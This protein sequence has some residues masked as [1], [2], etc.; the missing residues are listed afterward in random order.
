[1][2]QLKEG[3]VMSHNTPNSKSATP[4]NIKNLWA[5]TPESFRHAQVLCGAEFDID[6]SAS[7][8]N[9]KCLAYLSE[10]DNAISQPW[11]DVE[12]KSAWCNPPF[13]LKREFLAKAYKERV[14]GLICMM[15]PYEPTT[16]WWREYV[17]GKAS[18]VYVPDGRYNFLHPETGK[19][20]KGVSFASCFV[21][22]T[23][24]MLE[25][26]YVH[27]NRSEL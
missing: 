21:V 19:E 20:I 3:K 27:F 5:T 4:D 13:D 8:N 1:M 16:K 12:I 17:H 14:N 25:T 22:F 6:V 11:F 18:I 15:I 2:P 26:Q 7:E 23:S 10:E 24:M 9:T